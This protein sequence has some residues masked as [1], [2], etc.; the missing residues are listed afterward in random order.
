MKTFIN[1]EARIVTCTKGGGALFFGG[2]P[3]FIFGIIISLGVF[4]I[5]VEVDSESP[6]IVFS[7]LG[8]GVLF[9]GT[10]LMFGRIGLTIDANKHSLQ[11]WWGFTFLSVNKE[12]ISLLG[13][14]KISLTKAQRRNGKST[15]TVYPVTLCTENGNI[16]VDS[17]R[18]FDEARQQSEGVAKALRLDIHD[19]TDLTKKVRSYKELDLSI[20]ESRGQPA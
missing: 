4:G 15:Y 2:I 20:R 12:K 13:C 19:D 11:H 10:V 17:S 8:I 16:V 5:G 9:V 18:D 3:F 7:I 1:Q 6:L 14:N